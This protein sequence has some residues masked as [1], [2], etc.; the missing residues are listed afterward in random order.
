LFAVPAEAQ[1]ISPLIYYP[2]P[3][4]NPNPDPEAPWFTVTAGNASVHHGYR[5]SLSGAL[6]YNHETAVPGVYK[7]GFRWFQ[8]EGQADSD[9]ALYIDGALRVR[10]NSQD[11][12]QGK[13]KGQAW[14]YAEYVLSAGAHEMKLVGTRHPT[15][16]SGYGAYLHTFEIKLVKE[17]SPLQ[18]K[19]ALDAAGKEVKARLDAARSARIAVDNAMA[20]VSR[21][22]VPAA[23]REISQEVEAG[24]VNGFPYLRNKR[25]VYLWA[26]GKSGGGLL[27]I[28]DLISGKELLAV[29]EAEAT[30]WKVDLKGEGRLSYKNAG[31]PLKVKFD[32]SVGEGKLSFTWALRGVRV[33]VETWLRSAESLAR[34]RITVRAGSEGTGLKTVAFPVVKGILPFTEGA[35]GDEILQTGGIGGMTGS[36]LIS[37]M[38]SQVAYPGASMQFTTLMADG[39]G[40]YFAEEDGQANRKH[41]AWTP[42]T[43]RG[44]LT[45]SISHPVLNWGAKE[46]VREYRSPGDVVMGPFQGD[47]FDAARIYRKWALTAPWSRKGPI[48]EREDFPRWLARL[49]YWM[50]APLKHETEIELPFMTQEY[51][52]LPDT[53]CK[54]FGYSL[55]AYPQLDL[56]PEYLPPRLGSEGFARV[57]KELRAK[58]IR[59]VPYVNG[60]LWNTATESYRTEDAERRGGILLEQGIVPVTSAGSPDL[61]AGMCPATELWRKKLG[62][63]TKEL[64]GKY[65]VSGVYLDYLTNHN[66]DCFNKEHG[67][68][69]AGGNYWSRGVHGLYEHIRRGCKELDPEAM[70]CGEMA[71]EWC[72]DVLDTMHSG[73]VSSDAPVYLA[74]YHGYTQ[75]FGG[76]QN[77]TTP[78][79]IGR[80]WL[81]GTQN[82]E[83]SVM[84]WLAIGVFG[85]RGPYYRDLLRCHAQF[86]RPYLG[87][88]EMLRPPKIEGDLPILP[89]TAC[90]QY[91]PAFPVKAVEGSA[92]RAPDGTVGVFFLNYDS[93]QEHEFTWTQDL[94]E[95]AE[96]GADKKLKVTRWTP[97]G[98]Q[99]VGQWEGGTLRQTMKIEPWG[100]IA[101]KLE[102]L[103]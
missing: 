38:A 88:G 53:I 54:D 23:M 63:L 69:I 47:W 24:I 85:K 77:C 90:A 86:A 101:L 1:T 73:S 75:I 11:A 103:P 59:V 44:T 10:V 2:D 84:P 65:G 76:V 91:E 46:L 19:A 100:L 78:Q 61:G 9:I 51:F 4:Y 96:I 74:V 72:I 48:S 56:N 52:D 102:V 83:N 80:W 37:G 36:P 68:A 99:A 15:S 12:P 41:F 17:L 57:V 16:G 33:E 66:A 6:T 94:N 58:G 98:E 40:F 3:E 29:D 28:R 81:M 49:G 45:F 5:T 8:L 35:K 50:N 43:E 70:L 62:D 30:S 34:S 87:Y 27:R 60:Y 25:V 93:E 22:S 20:K 71:A 31:E 55:G 82:G 14:H 32:A 67:H 79:T 39:R 89:G 97:Q 92:W 7:I 18:V 64:V 26:R 42:D 13:N 95:I 21:K